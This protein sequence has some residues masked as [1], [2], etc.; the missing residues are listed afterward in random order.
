MGIYWENFYFLTT[1]NLKSCKKNI[2]KNNN[3]FSNNEYIALNEP[4]SK[5]NMVIYL[6]H[7]IRYTY[8]INVGNVNFT[9]IMNTEQCKYTLFLLN[10]YNVNITQSIDYTL[11]SVF[12]FK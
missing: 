10:I 7:Y 9:H 11:A 5:F 1:W 6:Y 3:N 12:S 4:P 2:F 8:L